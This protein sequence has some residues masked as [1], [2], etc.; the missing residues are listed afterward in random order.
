M[1]RTSLTNRSSIPKS[2]I[3]HPWAKTIEDVAAFYNVN[4]EAGL[5][6]ERVRRDLERYGPNGKS[7]R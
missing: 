4:E 2:T 5:S 6:E 7:I 3:D 1:Q